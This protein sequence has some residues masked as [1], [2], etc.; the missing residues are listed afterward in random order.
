MRTTPRT[1]SLSRRGLLAAGGAFGVGALLT[2]CGGGGSA[3]SG[4]SG[5][6]SGGD[7]WTFKDDRGTTAEAGR[8]PKK[9]TAFT[10]TAAALHDFGIE[11]AAVFGPTTLKDGKPDPQAG[12]LDVKKVKIL[13]NAWGEFNVEQY[14]AL[15]PELLV[16][17]MLEAGDLWYV[18]ADSKKKILGLAPSVGIMTSKVTLTHVIRRYAELAE[19]LGADLGAKKVTDAKQRFERASESLRKAAKANKGLKVLCAS[20]S[21]EL[22]YVSDPTVYADL[23][24]FAELGVE[25]VRPGKVTGGFFESLSWENA[26]TYPADL[27]L[28]DNRTAAL[29][30][31]DLAS[32]PTWAGLP[33]V[34]AGQITPWLSEPRYS[35]TGC[36]PLVEALATAIEKAKKVS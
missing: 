7:S 16:T 30:P 36:A 21:A 27:I 18:P 9:I 6:G 3:D 4:D 35:Y 14:A 28:L 23:A 8:T 32:K 13:G 11:C 15:G 22:L 25:F 31:K 10:G 5:P 19:S 2:A 12:D 26:G 24:Y 20:G 17:N 34:K 33:A 1:P 29:Q